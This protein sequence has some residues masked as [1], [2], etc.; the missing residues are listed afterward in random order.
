MQEEELSQYIK[1]ISSGSEVALRRF[2]DMYGKLII[3]FI[4]S[5]VKSRESAEEVLQDVLMVIVTHPPDKPIN[6]TKGWLFKVIQNISKKKVRED[7]LMQTESLS[8]SNEILSEEDPTESVEN[9]IDQIEALRCL[10][11]VEQQCV[12][13]CVF[14]QMK[15][16]QVAEFL[17]MPY[18]KVCNKELQSVFILR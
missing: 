7:Q 17:D 8:D 12:I 3:S 16:T 1:E 14:G 18:N 10:D 13:M 9:S 11:Q 5:I 15:L 4:L 6:N 2:Y